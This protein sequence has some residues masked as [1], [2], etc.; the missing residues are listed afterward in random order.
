M[1]ELEK[2]T[3]EFQRTTLGE[4]LSKCTEVQRARFKKFWPDGP[5][6]KQLPTAF[7]LVLRTVKANEKEERKEKVRPRCNRHD[8]CLKANERYIANHAGDH[9]PA[10]FHCHDDECEDC[11]GC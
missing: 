1:T 4:E 3:E 8:D 5:S 6:G 9:P 2:R 10:S 7:A 11:F